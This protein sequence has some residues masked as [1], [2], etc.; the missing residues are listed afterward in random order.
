MTPIKG[1]IKEQMIEELEQLISDIHDIS[2]GWDI[3]VPEDIQ[4]ALNE[5]KAA[6]GRAEDIIE[7]LPE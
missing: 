7:N 5:A 1:S 2:T 6:L 3:E 4:A